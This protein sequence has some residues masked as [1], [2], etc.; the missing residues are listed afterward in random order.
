[1]GLVYSQSNML[2]GGLAERADGGLTGL[3]ERAVERLNKLGA[4]VDVSHCGD[5]TSLEAIRLS[6]D[7]VVISHA[8]AREVWPTRR[9]KPDEV[10]TACAERGGII[11]IEAAPHTTISKDH[12]EHS[13]ESIM[14]HFEYCVELVGIDHVTFGPD[15]MFGD[16]V[17]IHRVFADMFSASYKRKA[18]D[19]PQV[20]YVA[21][22][23]NPTECFP[24]IVRWLVKHN[25]SDDEIRKVIGK[26]TL[27]VLRQV[28][29][30]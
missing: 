17:S 5:R 10:I 7:P 6:E 28:W 1:M 4:V 30:K 29:R 26:N 13:L 20:E 15:T 9:M 22:M 3:G 2:G 16:H 27:R 24:N 11:G 25:Y 18:P 8:G 19:F 23:E 14:D 21:G 12:R